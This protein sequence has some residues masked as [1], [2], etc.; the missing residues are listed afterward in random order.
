[1][2]DFTKAVE[3]WEVYAWCRDRGHLDFLKK[4]RLCRKYV[5]GEHWSPQLQAR[6]EREGK[7][8]LTI[9]K[10][11]S[12]L[13]TIMG[14]QINTQAD[15]AYTPSAG[16]LQ[17]V[18]DALTKFW[19]HVSKENNFV[20][21]EEM[22]FDSGAIS[23]RGFFDVRM[24]FERNLMGNIDISYLKAPSVV[25]NPDDYMYDPDEWGQ[26]TVTN[27]YSLAQI[28][29]Y[30]GKEI[31]E[32][33]KNRTSE[34]EYGY[35]SIDHIAYTFGGESTRLGASW[36]GRPDERVRKLIR[37]LDRQYWVTKRVEH[38]VDPRTGDM[39]AIPATWDFNRISEYRARNQLEVIK[40]NA[41]QIMWTVSADRTLISHSESPYK[42]FTVIPYF[43][44]FHEG[45]TIGL[46]EN[47]ISPQDLLNKTSSQELHIVNTT[48]NSG[49]QMEEGQLINMTPQELE[50]KGAQSGL[51]IVR[52]P[53]SNPLEKI[54][55]NQVPTGLDRISFKADENLKE[56]SGVSESMR[57]MDRAD[58]AAKAIRAK[59]VAGGVNL[60]KAF[61]N[62][63]RTRHLIARNV[64]DLAQQ[65]ITE[66]RAFTLTGN[67]VG[68][69]GQT[70]TIN[71]W[72]EKEGR[73]LNDF[74]QGTY[75]VVVTDV[76]MRDSMQDSQ[77]DEAVRLRT[78]VGVP[79]PD[80][81][82]IEHSHLANKNEIIA[83]L[84]GNESS[85]A[86]QQ[87]AEL[88]AQM[89]QLEMQKAQAEIGKKKADTALTMARAQSE[90]TGDDGGQAQLQI[91][92]QKVQMQ[93]QAELQRIEIER[94]RVQQE[95][96]LARERAM[97]EMQIKQQEMRQ[98]LVLMR[99]E[100][101]QRQQQAEADH[102]MKLAQGQQALEQ[103]DEA[104]ALGLE[105]QAQTHQASL[106]QSQEQSKV[107]VKTAQDMAK[108]KVAASKTSGKPAAKKKVAKK[109][110][111]KRRK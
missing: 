91:E 41:K 59:Q 109:A 10:I 43:P 74:T 96:Q 61:T 62:L 78:E 106:Q 37:V 111:A 93:Q 9:N 8:A 11:F 66:E 71:E 63:I 102:Q 22:V 57:G 65:Y 60:V 19:L 44:F 17:E 26:V 95:M 15:I 69:Q 35:D 51:V 76:P 27:W 32:E 75:G 54:Q 2:S 38:F 52:R 85:E 73:V 46:V 29:L 53:G 79:I 36:D 13:L 33:F 42:H 82:I 108:A 92:A 81:F 90:L 70:I 39:K 24:N 48:A 83:A 72:S 107:K 3:N 6:L 101:Q 100:A 105:Q 103:K 89:K 80:R 97:L 58:V 34:F 104:H 110:S 47:L 98:K 18:A 28:E 12:T 68:E 7:P 55:P 4:D 25:L 40:A 45:R 30:W 20:W 16:G 94:Q 31:A 1:M 88:E 86:Q 87:L 56:I 77:F 67:T 50:R 64:R 84:E 49:W 14:E 5:Y 21:L 99:M 23:S